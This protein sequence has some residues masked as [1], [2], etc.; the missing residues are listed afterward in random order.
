[1]WGTPS[2]NPDVW[3]NGEWANLRE[4]L[5]LQESGAQKAETVLMA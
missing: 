1:M 3:G 2:V 4:H 5:L